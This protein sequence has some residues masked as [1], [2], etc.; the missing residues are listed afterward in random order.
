[1]FIPYCL[2]CQ[3]HQLCHIQGLVINLVE[4]HEIELLANS[5]TVGIW[6]QDIEQWTLKT[7]SNFENSKVQTNIEQYF[8]GWIFNF[9][10]LHLQFNLQWIV[11]TLDNTIMINKLTWRLKMKTRQVGPLRL[12]LMICILGMLSPWG[13]TLH[14]SIHK[15]RYM[16]ISSFW[17]RTLLWIQ[18][19]RVVIER[20]YVCC[21]DMGGCVVVHMCVWRTLHL[22]HTLWSSKEM[23]SLV[24]HHCLRGN[25]HLWHTNPH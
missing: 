2:F 23:A 12:W 16:K 21:Y 1:V 15:R 18:S 7:D 5:W 20:A 9:L 8:Q 25:C 17:Q 19:S 4:W 14:I 11:P 10:A 22:L 13:F 24:V 6:R 3:A